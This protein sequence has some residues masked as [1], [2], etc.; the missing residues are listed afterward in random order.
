[1]CGLQHHHTA[2]HPKYGPSCP[3]AAVPCSGRYHLVSYVTGGQN[4]QRGSFSSNF[5][6][7]RKGNPLSV[8]AWAA[9]KTKLKQTCYHKDGTPDQVSGPP[10]LHRRIIREHDGPPPLH[11]AASQSMPSVMN[12][13]P[14]HELT[15]LLVVLRI[16]ACGWTHRGSAASR[17]TDSPGSATSLGA[18]SGSGPATRYSKT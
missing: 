18:G 6:A 16:L 7:G 1:M 14:A 2:V 12:V 17:Q 4:C 13:L 8:G 10:P 9:I 15:F 11:N 3:C 5:M